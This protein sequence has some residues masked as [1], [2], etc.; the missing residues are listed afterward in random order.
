[1]KNI[2]STYTADDLW[3]I[4][5][6]EFSKDI[7]NIREAQ[8]ALGN[9]YLG[10][11]GIYEE[12]P[13]DSSPATFIA[14]LY[15]KMAAQVS[16]M[17]NLPNPINF[18]F[19]V[20]GEKIDAVAM[21]VV[22]HRRTLNMKKALLVRNTLYQDVKKNRY[23][24]QSLRFLSQHN[25]NIGVMQ[26]VLTPL[27][28]A[29]TVDVNTGIDT[30]VSNAG[31]LSEG[32]KKHFRVKELG[33]HRRAGYL[34]A[35]TFDKKYTIVYWA[36]FYYTIDGKKIVAEDNVFRL[37]LKK[38]QTVVFTKVFCIKH[39]PYKSSYLVQKKNTFGIFDKAFNSDFSSLLKNHI[40]AW[41]KLWRKADVIIEGTANLQQNMRFNIYHM[42]ICAHS[43]NGL[44]SIGARTLS[45]EGYRGHIFW[46][47]EI[48]LLPFY[49]FTFP[50]IAK[51]MLIYRYKRLNAS[52]EIAKQNGYRGAQF[53]WESADTGQEETPEWAHDFDRTIIKIHTH[54]MEHHI[55]ADIAYAT[56]KYYVATKD[57]SFMDS[58]GY[59]IIAESAR[60]W[61]SRVTYNSK[62]KKCDICHVIGPDEFHV[63]VNN[64]AFTN[65]IAKWNLITAA[66][67]LTS[68]KT[69]SGFYEKLIKKLGINDKEIRQWKKIASQITIRFNKKKIIEQFDGYFG[70]KKVALN[71]ADE[72]GILLIPAT[73]K[74]KNLSKTQIIKQAD[75]LMLMVLLDDVFS[76]ATKEANYDFYISR[77]VHKSSL[78][79]PMHAL[80]ACEVGDL[81]RAY[82]LFNVSLRTDISNLYGNTP[83]GMHAASL[84]GT[85]QALVFG[86]AGIKIK[87]EELS[88]SPRMPHSWRKLVFSLSWKGDNLQL[89]VTNSL[90]KLKINSSKHKQVKIVI[91]GK[92]IN[93]K[94]NMTHNF[95]SGPNGFKKEDYY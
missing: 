84:G 93:V 74:A 44:S 59:E 62:N 88:I 32:R 7:Q 17:V 60:F 95:K 50:N 13:Y 8:F 90:V 2:Y 85:W 42:L 91:F 14:G 1:M 30:S 25:K 67:L 19:S 92:L 94:T 49:L 87:K 51:N 65:M 39:F 82:N 27:D 75:V 6:T 56:Y 57:E 58:Y 53:A 9:G 12:I 38:G 20:E 55:T 76:P 66:K 86:F 33:Q 26:T 3:L 21:D 29:C 36:G 11:R 72:N 52:R 54:K 43:D 89:E 70:L 4:K 18:K 69:R 24:Y 80:I 10:S 31:V 35:E 16:E 48:F 28:S 37:K 23:E 15:D 61:A 68:L 71:R 34:V 63:D 40:F 81:H 5:E 64:N 22:R 79:A 47:A 46:D 45:G 78:S 83:E 41:D 73:I 77:T